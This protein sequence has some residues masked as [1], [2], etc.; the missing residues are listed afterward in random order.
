MK[1]IKKIALKKTKILSEEEMKHLF[2]CVNSNTL[3][4]LPR[5]YSTMLL[6]L[7]FVDSAFAMQ[8]D[9]V[10]VSGKIVDAISQ[11]PLVDVNVVFMLEDSTIVNQGKTIDWCKK[12]GINDGTVL[13]AYNIPVPRAGK[14]IIFVSSPEHQDTYVNIEIPE[15]EYGKRTMDW[16]AEDIELERS[17]LL[18]EVEIKASKI[19]MVSKGDTVV[20]NASAFQL[21]EGSMLDALI[22]QLPGVR[23]TDGGQIFVNEEYVSA[24]LV[25]G[26]DFFQGNPTVALRNLP[27]YTVNKVKAYHR[28]DKADYLIKRDSI[29]HLSDELVL[30]IAL[31][32]DYHN[33]WL[34]NVEASYGSNERYLGRLFSMFLSDKQRLTAI[35]NLNNVGDTNKPDRDMKSSAELLSQQPITE[36]SGGF[37]YF[38][39]MGQKRTFSTVL[40]VNRRKEETLTE[41][42]SNI[43]SGDYQSF[44]RARSSS[45]LRRTEINW[46]NF[47]SI[48]FKK[49]YSEFTFG[50]EYGKSRQKTHA[51]SIELN[52][53]PHEERRLS[54][55]DSVLLQTASDSLL[56]TLVNT[57]VEQ[58]DENIGR[59]SLVASSLLK[60]KEPL[61]GNPMSLYAEINYENQHNE[62]DGHFVLKSFSP[63]QITSRQQDEHGYLHDLN[64]KIHFNYECRLLSNIKLKVDYNLSLE[65]SKSSRTL[66]TLIIAP[67]ADALQ[68][69]VTDRENSYDQ[70]LRST[71]HTP[72]FQFHYLSPRWM[73]SLHLPVRFADI[74]YSGQRYDVV[75]IRR[76]YTAFEPSLKINS[77]KGLAFTYTLS[78]ANPPMIYL[79]GFYDTSNPLKIMQSA[80][81]L[82]NKNSHSFMLNYAHTQAEKIRNI[83]VQSHFIVVQ[84]EVTLQRLYD[85]STGVTTFL[86][87][88]IN[89]TYD[90]LLRGSLSQ[91]IDRQKHFVP[92][93]ITQMNLTRT[94]GFSGL[95]ADEAV[96][97]TSMKTLNILGQLGIRY[98]ARDMVFRFHVKGEWLHGIP[99]SSSLVD[100]NTYRFCYAANALT[101]LLWG[102]QFNVNCSFYTVRGYHEEAMNTNS[103]VLNLSLSKSFLRRKNLTI[104]FTG[105]D[106]L[107]N[108]RNI[109]CSVN[110]NGRIET[111]SNSLSRYFMLHFVYKFST[112]EKSNK[113]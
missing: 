20:Y 6:F 27:A 78:Q 97:R 103:V 57:Y 66:D 35:A 44:A 8:N 107:N 14:Y 7:F 90:F 76:R 54:A 11:V 56:H 13:I 110:T 48:P 100:I 84:N 30:D 92:E 33:T 69:F 94:V 77:N 83:G 96:M 72:E 29:E 70:N 113:I 47:I 32:K 64:A 12:Y 88:N 58:S 60:W 5:L 73:L 23:L 93:I 42:A 43:V 105:F 39:D 91:A 62:R 21:A 55:L 1:Q 67:D 22:S 99:S 37:E 109:R 17:Y 9:S 15:G 3:M 81:S 59:K 26:Q 108:I 16:E 104:Q 112:K 95:L 82:I 41:T 79:T 86:P 4:I 10:L 75:H 38:I 31:K 50:G 106:V 87:R 45:R 34:A 80:T 25:N 28:G 40:T 49:V 68:L 19:L 36:I 89:G 74:K 65:H 52:R 61:R 46:R 85:A 2:G 71:N 102:V 101:P 63:T 53:L 111:W 51:S 24:L 18:K 98:A